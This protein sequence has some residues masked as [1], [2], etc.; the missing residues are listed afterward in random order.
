MTQ[1]LQHF[2][3]HL[4]YFL[5]QSWS[6]VGDSWVPGLDTY[7]LVKGNKLQALFSLRHCKDKASGKS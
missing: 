7:C 4:S 2:L 1:K 6:E 3:L 5:F